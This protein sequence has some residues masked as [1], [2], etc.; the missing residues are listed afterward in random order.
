MPTNLIIGFGGGPSKEKEPAEEGPQ[1]S[2]D[3]QLEANNRYPGGKLARQLLL[4]ER[5]LGPGLANVTSN[6]AAFA[7]TRDV[8][9]LPLVRKNVQRS[10]GSAANNTLSDSDS[11]DNSDRSRMNFRL[12]QRMN[13]RHFRTVLFRNPVDLQVRRRVSPRR[14]N[15]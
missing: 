13:N 11:D 5:A 3:R 12:E 4:E 9:G 8:P 10:H 15:H 7:G 6:I 2:L 14:E 1:V